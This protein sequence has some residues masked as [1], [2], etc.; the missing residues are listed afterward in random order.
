MISLREK[1]MIDFYRKSYAGELRPD[2]EEFVN[3][4]TFLAPWAD[5]KR[6][7][8]ALFDNQ[9]ILSR[10]IDYNK[11]EDEISREVFGDYADRNNIIY[12]YLNH[13][14]NLI[15]KYVGDNHDFSTE[16][17]FTNQW[18]NSC[19]RGYF[20]EDTLICN[21]AHPGTLTNQKWQFK[22]YTLELLDP[23]TKKIVK[24]DFKKGESKIMRLFQKVG[25]II[26]HDKQMF[27]QFRT[28]CS[29]YFNTSKIEGE[30]CLSIHPLDYI[31]MSENSLNWQ[32]CMNWLNHGCYRRGT[33]EMMNSPMVVVG[34]FH[35][36]K[37][38]F[39][40]GD[41]YEWNNKKWR[42][43]FVINDEIIC[44]IKSY[45]Y[46]SE[47]LETNCIKW[48]RDLAVAHGKTQYCETIHHFEPYE[49]EYPMVEPVSNA[50]YN[51]FNCTDSGR[52]Y[53]VWDES[54]GNRIEFNYSG[55]SECVWC[56]ETEDC[57][58][59]GRGVLFNLNQEDILCSK[60]NAYVGFC[61]S[62]GEK[63]LAEESREDQDG[64]IYHKDCWANDHPICPVTG[65]EMSLNGYNDYKV[66]P[67]RISDFNRYGDEE[68]ISG[69]VFFKQDCWYTH[70]EVWSKY[71]TVSQP[72]YRRIGWHYYYIIRLSAL[73][74]EGSELFSK[75]FF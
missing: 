53:G 41:S 58:E 68:L 50:M 75:V 28:H 43:L 4:D 20:I 46:E 32:S 57:D 14:R 26:G 38:P 13:F 73:T 8:L 31:T 16:V 37:K 71:F 66:I 18:G 15:Y 3:T 9:L 55:L 6:N 69:K 33:I 72:D 27:E 45:P 1:E 29:L 74:E 60:C 23:K 2:H 48:L 24:V 21:L 11:D 56:G 63:I 51:D 5:A 40:F 12:K 62:C 25:D 30:L 52:H 17:I 49:D 10:N 54:A 67:V 34:Y 70:P 47:M 7:L 19:T 64:A 42:C 61:T 36:P 39:R 59:D 22:S 65:I 35:N 44:H